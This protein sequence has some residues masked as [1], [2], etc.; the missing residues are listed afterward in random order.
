[1]I[2][3]RIKFFCF[4]DNEPNILQTLLL[5]TAIPTPTTLI[6]KKEPFKS[7]N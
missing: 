2:G 3:V 6:H 1:M 7:H 4:K 5:T